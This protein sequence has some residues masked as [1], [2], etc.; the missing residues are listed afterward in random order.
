[1][2]ILILY[3]HT[4]WLQWWVTRC[5][6]STEGSFPQLLTVLVTASCQMS[7]SLGSTLSPRE[8]RSPRSPPS[9]RNSSL[10]SKTPQCVRMYKARFPLPKP[11][12][13]G[14]VFPALELS[15]RTRGWQGLVVTA[16]LLLLL[17]PASFTPYFC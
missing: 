12:Q 13:P 9:P 1:M 4:W 11:R 7:H 16:Q 8:A 10:H 6:F 17:I 15:L 14:R 3:M 2:K 5:P